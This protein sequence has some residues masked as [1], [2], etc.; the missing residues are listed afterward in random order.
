MHT[1]RNRHRR[2]LVSLEFALILPLLLAL[3]MALIEGGVMFYSWL[4]IQKAAQSGA[5]FAATGQGEDQGTRMSQILG[6]AEEWMDHLDKGEKTIVVR[7]WPAG[8][9]EGDGVEGDAGGPCQMVEVDVTYTYHPFTPVI[10]SALPETI[11]LRGTDRKLNEPWRP[12][13]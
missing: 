13:D 5:R 9:P 8:L 10:G 6:V 12:C 3:A 2:G 1:A 7:S 11:P 4:T